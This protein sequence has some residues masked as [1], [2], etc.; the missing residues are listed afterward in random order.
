MLNYL[1]IV[2]IRNPYSGI[3]EDIYSSN[4]E[5][6]MT[7]EILTA[8]AYGIL[9]MLG[10]IFG[11]RRAKSQVSLISG[12]ASGLLLICGGIVQLWGQSWGL[13]LA[14]IVTAILE[15]VFAI[16]LVKTRKFMPAGLM[17]IFG[18]IALVIFLF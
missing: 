11:Y 7:V 12:I 2:K 1:P 10:G 9:A 3:N 8:I 13:L 5:K 4:L 6:L 15:I 14:T 18:M 17:I 16:R